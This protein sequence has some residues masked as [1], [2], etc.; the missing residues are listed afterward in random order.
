MLATDNVTEALESFS[1][2]ACGVNG[3]G[4]P[5]QAA[6]AAAFCGIFDNDA[7]LLILDLQRDGVQAQIMANGS[8]ERIV[9]P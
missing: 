7:T 4:Q 2:M 3:D 9:T 6:V 5:N 1:F 8:I